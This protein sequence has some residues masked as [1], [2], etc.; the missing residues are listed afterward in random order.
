MTTEA[1]PLGAQVCVIDIGVAADEGTGA[2]VALPVVAAAARVLR[3]MAT[4]DSAGVY[5]EK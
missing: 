5:G 4:F 3:D 1:R 2:A